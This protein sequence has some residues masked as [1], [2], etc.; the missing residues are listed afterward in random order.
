MQINTDLCMNEL[1]HL[2]NTKKQDFFYTI[3]PIIYFNE[4]DRTGSNY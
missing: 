1:N 3:E 4:F 2:I